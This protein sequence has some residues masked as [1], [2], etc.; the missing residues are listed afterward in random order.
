MPPQRSGEKSVVSHGSAIM[1]GSGPFS[2]GTS[3][4]TQGKRA[5]I[6]LC[7]TLENTRMGAPP[8]QGE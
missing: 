6:N 5:E 1:Q 7:T 4:L 2:N 8:S 3:A